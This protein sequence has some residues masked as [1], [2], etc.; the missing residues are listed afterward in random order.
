MTLKTILKAADQTHS[1]AKLSGLFKAQRHIIS[2]K[3]TPHAQK[4]RQPV[5]R[6]LL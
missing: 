1:H 5:P 6:V 4:E 2:I 3:K